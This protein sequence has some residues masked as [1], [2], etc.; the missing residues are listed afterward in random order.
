MAQAAKATQKA[1][2]KASARG[3]NALARGDV[4]L[5]LKSFQQARKVAPLNFDACFGLARALHAAG[6]VAGAVDAFEHALGTAPDEP[7]ALIALGSLALQLD[8]PEQELA[9]SRSS[10]GWNRDP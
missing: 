4:V 6:D 5:A 7:R 8:M 10:P 2:Q 9:F 1:A 3:N